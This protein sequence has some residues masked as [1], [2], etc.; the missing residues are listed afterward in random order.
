MTEKRQYREFI[1]TI[2]EELRNPEF[3]IAYLNDVLASGDRKAFL[4]ALK[5]VIE[6]RGNITGFAK[7]AHTPRQ[8]IYR[9]LSED[10]NPTYDKLFS[11]LDAMNINV[12]L[13]LKMS[14]VSINITNKARSKKKASI[15]INAP[16]MK[17]A[18]IIKQPA[19]S[20]SVAIHAKKKHT[21]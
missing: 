14:D 1:D 16:K 19:A 12:N 21:K 10:G 9:M 15:A 11:L 8:N 7:A 20:D 13:S 17:K 18:P 6:A 4:L 2:Q 5:D 3:A